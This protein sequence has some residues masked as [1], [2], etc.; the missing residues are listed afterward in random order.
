MVAQWRT[1]PRPRPP[2][3]ARAG[4]AS[5]SVIAISSSCVATPLPSESAR[6]M[7]VLHSHGKFLF[8][9]RSV[10]VEI[11]F[12]Q[13][14]YSGGRFGL[15]IGCVSA[16]PVAPASCWRTFCQRQLSVAVFIESLHYSSSGSKFGQGEL[17]ILILIERSEERVR[18]A[19]PVTVTASGAARAALRTSLSHRGS[20]SSASSSD[21]GW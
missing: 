4:A 3:L 19:A 8:S 17:S 1:R 16:M 14:L 9:K 12:H 18:V 7:D 2:A 11:K 20:S 21:S 6:A 15:W 10:T 5:F 13:C